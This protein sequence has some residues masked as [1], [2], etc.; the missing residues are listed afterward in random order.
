LAGSGKRSARRSARGAGA[1]VG[2]WAG[3]GGP[4]LFCRMASSMAP[5]LGDEICDSCPADPSAGCRRPNS[6]PAPQRRRTGMS[7]PE[8]GARRR[9]PLRQ[10][11]RM[12]RRRPLHRQCLRLAQRLTGPRRRGCP[13]MSRGR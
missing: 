2:S 7:A 10:A 3:H 9:L 1:A 5:R 11:G 12:L 6:L 4:R 8:G 13:S